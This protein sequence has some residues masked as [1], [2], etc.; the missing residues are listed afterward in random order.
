MI[1]PTIKQFLKS[2]NFIEKAAKLFFKV[3]EFQGLLQY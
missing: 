3:T 2:V 1:P